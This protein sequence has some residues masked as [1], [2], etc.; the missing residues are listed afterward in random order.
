MSVYEEDFEVDI[1]TP[2]TLSRNHSPEIEE[3]IPD[4][5]G[6]GITLPRR[7]PSHSHVYSEYTTQIRSPEP[8]KPLLS[9]RTDSSKRS[10]QPTK[11]RVQPK[12]ESRIDRGRAPSRSVDSHSLSG[13]L[14]IAEQQV[15][16][17]SRENKALKA[18]L[19]SNASLD[20][21]TQME[22]VLREKDK[23]IEK[24]NVEVKTLRQIQQ[25]QSQALEK[26][27]TIM[28]QL[29][30]FQDT[31][32][33]LKEQNRSLKQK[34]TQDQQTIQRQV[35]EIGSLRE[36]VSNMSS[37]QPKQSNLSS[38]HVISELEQLKSKLETSNQ[39]INSLNKNKDSLVRRHKTEI[40]SLNS[41]LSN[42]QS[43][44]T[45]LE[46]TISEQKKELIKLK[47]IQKRYVHYRKI[48]LEKRKILAENDVEQSPSIDDVSL[49]N[50]PAHNLND[51]H[52]CGVG[53]SPFPSDRE[54]NYDDDF[55]E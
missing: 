5:S 39:T 48:A 19:D 34:R 7:S 6:Y 53:G 27:D 17:L 9:G 26:P 11:K 10:S 25:H 32:R 16:R 49:N 8:A 24:L 30:S 12:V 55:D 41:N 50:S 33:V 14:R 23:L 15:D 42:L 35:A 20:R 40:S 29:E 3:D 31:I 44:M 4:N 51:L 54:E 43:K 38:D 28:Q 1:P 52:D 37:N 36:K 18:R 2:R 45:D 21:L 46:S 22:N 47:E 13:R